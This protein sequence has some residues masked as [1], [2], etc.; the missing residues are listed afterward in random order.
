MDEAEDLGFDAG[1]GIRPK[2]RTR[3]VISFWELGEVDAHFQITI[4]HDGGAVVMSHKE[5]LA[6]LR[7]YL[8]PDGSE[9]PKR[10]RAFFAENFES[11][12]DTSGRGSDLSEEVR[13][14]IIGQAVLTRALCHW[15]RTWETQ[16]KERERALPTP[17]TLAPGVIATY[18]PLAWG[19]WVAT[20]D[21]PGKDDL[22]PTV[23]ISFDRLRAHM[24]RATERLPKTFRELAL[25]LA[26]S[27]ADPDKA[28]PTEAFAV[29][30]VG[31]RIIKGA[32]TYAR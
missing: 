15:D 30:K 25:A 29:A 22:P 4:H 2:G 26:L 7:D 3:A 17:L 11:G 1:Y 32:P 9:L 16:Y 23:W 20:I 21:N 24:E 27:E 13:A 6:S 19:E 5:K 14:Y 18:R 8:A 28:P 12:F 10:L 31:T